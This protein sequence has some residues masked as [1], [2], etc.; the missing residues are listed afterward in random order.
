MLL[1]LDTK[2][3]TAKPPRSEFGAITSRLKAAEPREVSKLDFCKHVAS[4]SAWVGGAFADGLD[5][6]SLI[7]WQ[8][9]ALD[10]DNED[11]D[12]QPL[13]FDDGRFMSP[14][15]AL[16]RCES[17]HIAPML[18]YK[19]LSSTEDNPHF[20]LVFDMGEPVTDRDVA[21]AVIESLLLAFPE[22]DKA[23]KNIN[24]LFLGSNGVVWVVA[25]AWFV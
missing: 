13:G 5:P 6:E 8:L 25:E 20:R 9:A 4:G 15:R 22:A 19:T 7:S 11:G 18:I 21:E 17:L 14:W 10:F 12:G 2:R 1:T 16:A 3:Y 23:C 24:R